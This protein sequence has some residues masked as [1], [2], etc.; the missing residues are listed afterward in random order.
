MTRRETSARE[1]RRLAARASGSSGP[2]GHAL[3][4]VRSALD[5]AELLVQ[6]VIRPALRR[7]HPPDFTR[8]VGEI[9]MLLRLADRVLVGEADRGRI[10]VL[11]WRISRVARSR[12]ARNAI[13]ARP[14]RAGIAPARARLPAP[15]R[16]P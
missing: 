13:A 12:S 4:L 3:D 16:L 5:V 9:A 1:A 6:H 10:A 2:S 15:A 14:S 11:S 7:A 8:E